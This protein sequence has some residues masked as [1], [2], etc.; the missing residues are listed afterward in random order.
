MVGEDLETAPVSRDGVQ[1]DRAWAVRN[2]DVGEQQGAR[3][4]P[5]LLG[6]QATSAAV[7][8]GR[9]PAAPVLRF[10][11][12]ETI[13]ADD[14][15]ASSRVSDHL[16]KKV[17]L[18]PLAPRSN[19]SH[20]RLGRFIDGAD[21]RREMGVLPGEDAPDMSSLPF[22]KLS[23]LGIFATPP[24][25]YFDAYPIHVLTT[26]SL[27][28]VASRSGNANIDARRYRPNIVIDSGEREG[29]LEAEWEGSRIEVG[30]CLF[31][32]EAPT[33]RCSM[34]GRAQALPGIDADKG[35]VRA[36]A[37]H[38]NRHLGAYATVVRGGQIRVGDPVHLL[39]APTRP[40]ARGF[41]RVERAFSRR[42][43]N[44]MMRERDV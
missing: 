42:V 43:L 5:K 4:L 39:P 24:G 15:R 11:D 18:V 3:K 10:P 23:E 25:T 26:A 40:V 41:R 37:E 34:P 12:G 16:G 29:L 9:A 1:G 7:D 31:A 44:W 36:V 33:V 32:V 21:L 2:L 13:P 35:V 14:P 28:F 8:S 27:G 22:K 19:L 38:A 20:Y 17:E 6:I 30:D